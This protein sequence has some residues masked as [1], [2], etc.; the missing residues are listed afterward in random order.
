MVATFL[1]IPARD[2]VLEIDSAYGSSGS[3]N[4]IPIEGLTNLTLKANTNRADTTD[5]DSEGIA[6]HLLMERG[7]EFTVAGHYLEDPLTGE[8]P[9]GQV[10]FETFATKV[11]TEAYVAFQLTSPGG[12]KR[13]FIGT[14]ESPGALGGGHNDPS[15]WGGTITV[16]GPVTY[17]PAGS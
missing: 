13:A 12:N 8:R 1:K 14:I 7:Q 2:F 17:T 5:F 10:A 4:F 6:E 9:D 16:S 3:P 15:G 11:G